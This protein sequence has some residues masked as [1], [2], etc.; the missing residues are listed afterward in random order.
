MIADS[1]YDSLAAAYE[2]SASRR[3]YRWCAERLSQQLPP[4][5]A[6]RGLELGCGTGLST[7]VF[8]DR[9]PLEWVGLDASSK[10]LAVARAKP[11]LASVV[12]H[13]GKAEKLPFPEACFDLITCN[14]ALHWFDLDAAV[15]EMKRV[16]V[17]GGLLALM[18]PLRRPAG[19]LLGNRL[20]RRTLFAL[21]RQ[22]QSLQSQGLTHEELEVALADWQ[23]LKAETLQ[24]AESFQTSSALSE[25]L[26]SRGSLQAVF[27]PLARPAARLLAEAE[28][29]PL[30][31]QW[32][33]ACILAKNE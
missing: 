24:V 14:V 11:Q 3:L 20:V 16:L 31:F 22:V 6:G 9:L 1:L 19:T 10:M 17:P 2:T 28:P 25:E 32:S 26:Q 15:R 12:F 5:S 21:R 27:G 30:D 23:V 4:L 33:F 13:D 8:C 18:V 29:M 7:E